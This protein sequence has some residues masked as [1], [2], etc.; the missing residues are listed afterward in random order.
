MNA[1]EVKIN[2]ALAKKVVT[3][4][5]KGLVSGLGKQE[6]GKACVEAVVCMAMGLPHGDNPPCVGANVRS[7]KIALN[8]CKWPSDAARTKGMRKLA[9]AQLGSDT[10]DQEEFLKRVRFKCVTRIL[11][12]I[13]Q[14]SIDEDKDKDFFKKYADLPKLEKAIKD[15]K[16]AKT[17]EQAKE[18]TRE[19][20]YA[21]AYASASASASASAYAHDYASAY[22]YASA[23]ASASAYAHD[24][25]SASA[26]AYAH[27]YAE[28]MPDFNLKILT[29]TADVAL[30]VLEELKS[31]GVKWLGLC[32]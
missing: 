31:P 16:K 26:S 27:D 3:L 21:S 2:R 25:A 13:L 12:I 14:N 15:L 8:D 20:R 30:E 9:V 17:F 11:P 28:K 23:S 4:V 22:A 19:A 29:M 18:A 1:S 6:P 10:I 24:Y 5:D 32:K 7:F